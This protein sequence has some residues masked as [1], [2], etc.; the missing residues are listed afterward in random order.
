MYKVEYRARQAR[1]PLA[2]IVLDKTAMTRTPPDPKGLTE[3]GWISASKALAKC[4][5]IGSLKETSGNEAQVI[6]PVKKVSRTSTIASLMAGSTQAKKKDTRAMY[7]FPSLDN[8]DFDRVSSSPEKP[9]ATIQRVDPTKSKHRPSGDL[10]FKTNEELIKTIFSSSSKSAA[11]TS[12]ASTNALV[13]EVV[14]QIPAALSSPSMSTVIAQAASTSG[15]RPLPPAATVP[16]KS[17]APASPSITAVPAPLPVAI[18]DGGYTR[19]Y[20]W[21]MEDHLTFPDFQYATFP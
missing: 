8:Y 20:S 15:T 3:Y 1:H 21:A 9:K 14:K 5:G 7:K 11:G 10:A 12:T 16:T 19:S 2:K 6:A 18:S 13:T 17:F 4:P